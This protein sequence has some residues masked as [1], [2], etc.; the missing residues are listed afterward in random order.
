MI[1]FSSYWLQRSFCPFF[2]LCLNVTYLVFFL[3]RHKDVWFY[4]KKKEKSIGT[5]ERSYLILEVT[6]RRAQ[7]LIYE[8]WLRWHC[9]DDYVTKKEQILLCLAINIPLSRSSFS[10]A[11]LF[12]FYVYLYLPAMKVMEKHE[13]GLGRCY[14]RF[15]GK[16]QHG[17]FMMETY[18]VRDKI[19]RITIRASCINLSF[20]LNHLILVIN[21]PLQPRRRTLPSSIS[22]SSSIS[23]DILFNSETF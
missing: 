2:W 18:G 5:F 9:L 1:F 10:N 15:M 23:W 13:S 11:T 20:E 17:Q 6:H 7:G 4:M 3:V 16:T 22:S 12:S 19:P 14:A 21:F 8:Y